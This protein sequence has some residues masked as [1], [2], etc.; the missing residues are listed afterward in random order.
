TDIHVRAD[1]RTGTGPSVA[2]TQSASI[3]VPAVITYALAYTGEYRPD[4]INACTI[5]I[6]ATAA[7]S[8]PAT[9]R[10]PVSDACVP[11]SPVDAPNAISAAPSVEA[12]SA[13]H[14]LKVTCSRANK[15]E[16]ADNN[17][18]STP[19]INNACETVVRASAANWPR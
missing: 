10:S 7:T 19:T 14:R 5:R 16:P 2:N 3:G 8:D 17:T 9:S 6:H 18:G 15:A 11:A 13:I 1:S 4:F 12:K